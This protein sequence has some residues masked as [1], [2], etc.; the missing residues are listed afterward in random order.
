LLI[1]G[2]TAIIHLFDFIITSARFWLNDHKEKSLNQDELFFGL[3][4][5]T[6]TSL[7]VLENLIEKD[8]SNLKQPA[9]NVSLK[10]EDTAVPILKF[11]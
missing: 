8:Q 4:Y 1:A 7:F 9:A 5:I 11:L 3:A 2:L 10:D 6:K